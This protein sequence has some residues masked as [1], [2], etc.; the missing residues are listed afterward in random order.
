MIELPNDANMLFSFV[1]M[2]LRDEYDSLDDMC[3]DL[4]I[5][6]NWLLDKLKASGFEYKQQMNKFW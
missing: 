6:K 4:D 1:N 5:Q 2:K 3:E